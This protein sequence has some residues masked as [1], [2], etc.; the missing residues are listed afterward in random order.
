MKARRRSFEELVAENKSSLLKD[1]KALEE[2]DKRLEKKAML[3]HFPKKKAPI[4]S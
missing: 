2:I 4:H 3:N 1:R